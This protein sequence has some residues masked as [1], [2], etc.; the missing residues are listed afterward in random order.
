MGQE[1]PISGN[2]KKGHEALMAAMAIIVFG[3]ASIVFLSAVL[4]GLA[5]RMR[6]QWDQLGGESDRARPPR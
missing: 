5:L 3:L 4:L 6:G 2:G 1:S